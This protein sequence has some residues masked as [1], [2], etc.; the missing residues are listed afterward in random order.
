M[1]SL[2]YVVSSGNEKVGM[3]VSEIVQEESKESDDLEAM[4]R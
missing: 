4:G 2:T 1:K 3:D